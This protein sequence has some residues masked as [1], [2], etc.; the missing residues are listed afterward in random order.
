MCLARV[1]LDTVG[2]GSKAAGL[3][4]TLDP[5]YES[6]FWWMMTQGF[7]S[8][9]AKLC[10]RFAASNRRVF[11]G[12]RDFQV[13]SVANCKAYLDEPAARAAGSMAD[14]ISVTRSPAPCRAKDPK[15]LDPYCVCSVFSLCVS[16]EARHPLEIAS[17][18]QLSKTGYTKEWNLSGMRLRLLRIFAST[19]SPS[20]RPLQC[21]A[22]FWEPR[23]LTRT[24][25]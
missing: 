1:L 6:L 18:I 14:A 25:Y 11:F 21:S 17:G 7:A 22:T 3:K 23:S 2:A 16:A 4:K 15:P 12:V 9:W 19:K 8:P 24:L 13:Q 10:R 20:M 5:R